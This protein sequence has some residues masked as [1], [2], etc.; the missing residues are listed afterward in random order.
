MSCAPGVGRGEKTRCEE[1]WRWGMVED[2]SVV[3]APPQGELIWIN[4]L[5]SYS[6]CYWPLRLALVVALWG[7]NCSEGNESNVRCDMPTKV[8]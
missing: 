5:R 7:T 8:Y 4:N 2:F 1:G 3:K 6:R